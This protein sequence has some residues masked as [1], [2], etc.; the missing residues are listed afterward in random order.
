MNSSTRWPKQVMAHIVNVS[1]AYPAITLCHNAKF[2][3]LNINEKIKIV[4]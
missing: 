3:E 4:Q 1:S 2:K